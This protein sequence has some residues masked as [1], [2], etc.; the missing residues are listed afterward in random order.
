VALSAG[1]PALRP[2]PAPRLGFRARRCSGAARPRRAAAARS[3]PPDSWGDPLGSEATC[4]A[5]GRRPCSLPAA[6]SPL[7]VPS[8]AL[9]RGVKASARCRRPQRTPRLV[10]GT[11]RRRDNLWRFW[12][13]PL[14]CARSRVPDLGSVFG[15]AVRWTR[16][17]ELCLAEGQFVILL[18]NVQ[19][20][21]GVCCNRRCHRV[22][23]QAGRAQEETC[24]VR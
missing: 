23:H 18:E 6:G 17:D 21:N 13:S 19:W 16:S 1:A 20:L 14:L 7:G 12:P 22:L 2:Q 15:I 9:Q 10:G 3:G 11:A 24:K 4:G 8:S 5:F